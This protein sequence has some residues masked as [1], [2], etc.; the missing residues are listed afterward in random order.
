V[1]GDQHAA[2]AQQAERGGQD[3][4][5]EAG[6]HAGHDQRR[7]QRGR[8]DAAPAQPPALERQRGQRADGQ[9]QRH[10]AAG[11]H[12]LFSAARWNCG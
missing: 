3:Q 8:P 1:G 11:H 6:R 2:A 7:E 12:E 5:A 10:G 4:E 9:R